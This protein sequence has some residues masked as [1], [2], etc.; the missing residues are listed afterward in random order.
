MQRKS[1]LLHLAT[2]QARAARDPD[3]WSCWRRFSTSCRS[4]CRSRSSTTASR[5]TPSSTT[6]RSRSWHVELDLSAIFHGKVLAHLRRLPGRPAHLPGDHELRLPGR[7]GGERPV[8]EEHQHQEG[9]HGRAHAAPPA[10]RALRPHPAL[11]A[12]P[13]PQGQAGRARDH[14]QGRGRAARRLHR[15]R[16]RAADVPRRP[17]ADGDHL[18]HD[19]ELA[20]AASSSLVLLAVQMAIIPRLRKPLLVLGRQRQLSARQ[21]AG[22]IA[23]TADGI[24]RDPRPWRGQLR[25]RRHLRAARA[26]SSR[27]ASSSTSKKFVAKFWNNF[28]SQ[29]TPFAIYLVGGYFAITGQM[30]V[31]AVVGVMLAYKDLPSPIKEL[32]DW[33]QQRQDVADQVRAGDRPVPARGHDG[34][35]SCRRCPTARRRRSAPSW[36]WPA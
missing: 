18:H 28:L 2:Q 19:A 33:D 32:I 7:R 16:L 35:R 10:L 29:A 15:R 21:L 9:P 13:L 23:E 20:A 12:G 3:A 30:D 11:P 1:V 14:D 36:R 5:A 26:A 17:G 31:G 34:P 25:A 6:R 8:Q 22:R 27:S 24:S 4:P